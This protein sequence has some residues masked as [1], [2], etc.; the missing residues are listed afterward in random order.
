MYQKQL[1]DE[2]V[3]TLTQHI[4]MQFE[5]TLGNSAFLR[6]MWLSS[7]VKVTRQDTHAYDSK[8]ILAQ[9]GL[10]TNMIYI[11]R[12]ELLNHLM[13]EISRSQAQTP[14]CYVAI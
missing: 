4:A 10:L 13:V 1:S 3:G 9:H 7:H 11:M 12:Y 14:N 6:F 8:T 5:S 2:L